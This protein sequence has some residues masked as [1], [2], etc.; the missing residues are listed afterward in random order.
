MRNPL[1]WVGL[2]MQAVS[3][4]WN[5]ANSNKQMHF[6]QEQ[7]QLNRDFQSQ[8]AEKAYLRQLKFWN[9]QNEYNLPSNQVERLR[10]AG[11]HPALYMGNGSMA[12]GLPPVPQASSSASPS[13]SQPSISF[14]PL[15]LSQ[16][17]LNN[18]A[19]KEHEEKANQ[20]KIDNLTRDIENRTRI[21]VQGSQIALNFENVHVSHEQAAKLAK[22]VAA[23]E[24]T[25]QESKARVKQILSQT[26]LLRSQT[27]YQDIQNAFKSATFTDECRK[28]AAETN[29]SVEEAKFCAKRIALSMLREQAAAASDFATV[30]HLD[31]SNLLL[32]SQTIGQ[33]LSNYAQALSNGFDEATFDYRVNVIQ[34]DSDFAKA[35]KYIDLGAQFIGSTIGTIGTFLLGKGVLTKRRRVSSG[36]SSF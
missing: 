18:A 32:R 16:S 14:D 10:S 5:Q 25:I 9:L 7:A 34:Q 35:S 3:N 29:I 26:T 2:G 28:F 6:Q 15:A 19:A 8:E 4:I 23:L 27:I 20:T 21:K 12:Q 24:Q 30:R 13:G 36:T 11:L 22:E 31:T 1:G 17:L 33:K